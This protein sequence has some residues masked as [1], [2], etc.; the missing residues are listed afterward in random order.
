MS[1]TE[2]FARL[3]TSS[4]ATLGELSAG[5]V[6]ELS[7]HHSL[8]V[9]WNRTLNLTSVAGLEEMVVRH[10]CESL[11]LGLHLPMASVSVLDVGSGAGFP[12]IPLAISRPD[13]RFTLAESHQR[14][15]VFLREATRH[16]GNVRVAAGRAEELRE[17]FD[18]VVSRAVKWPG[19]L[20]LASAGRA[21]AL[22]LLLGHDDAEEVLRQGDFDWLPAIPLPWGKRRLLVIGHRR[23]T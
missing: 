19:V 15:A 23:S 16:L 8:L 14:K 11:F 9:R 13:C 2:D 21:R 10:Y 20:R 7:R 18:W 6:S 4:F 17:T 22:A 3:L 12:G 1:E 5:Q